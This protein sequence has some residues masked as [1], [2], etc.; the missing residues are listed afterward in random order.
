M[1]SPSEIRSPTLTLTSATV[2]PVGA[3]TSYDAFTTVA[4]W[5]AYGSIDHD[6]VYY[7]QKVHSLRPLIERGIGR[8]VSRQ[9]RRLKLVLERG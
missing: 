8:D 6:G 9:L 7:G 3:G 5:R 1:R 4:N 2:P